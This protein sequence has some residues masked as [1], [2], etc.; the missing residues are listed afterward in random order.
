MEELFNLESLTRIDPSTKILYLAKKH[1][2]EDVEEQLK[3]NKRLDF[4]MTDKN[5][6]TPLLLAIKASKI[7]IMEK[8]LKAGADLFATTK[9]GVFEG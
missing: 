1:K 2:W 8:M 5:G 7:S 3:L 4:S 6:F 9:V